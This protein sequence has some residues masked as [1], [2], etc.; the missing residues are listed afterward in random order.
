MLWFVSFSV[1]KGKA[2]FLVA[3]QTS[4][5]G[6]FADNIYANS[7]DDPTYSSQANFSDFVGS[8]GTFIRDWSTLRGRNVSYDSI[9]D[10][11]STEIFHLTTT[12]TFIPQIF[13]LTSTGLIF[14]FS[15]LTTEFS[16]SSVGK[17]CIIADNATK[18]IIYACG[19]SGSSTDAERLVPGFTMGL[20]KQWS[21][22]TMFVSVETINVTTIR[23]FSVK[24]NS[25]IPEVNVSSDWGKYF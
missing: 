18:T 4:G 9:L 14:P 17:S 7:T 1:M 11:T 24:F 23:T 22:V 2:L 16:P 8:D 13:F 5:D 6:R 20:S 25:T 12:V 21:W 19:S 10:N 3:N 15:R